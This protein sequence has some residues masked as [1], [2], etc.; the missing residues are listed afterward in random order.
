VNPD[1][2]VY[3]QYERVGVLCVRVCV[4]WLVDW[5]VSSGRSTGVFRLVGRLRISVIDISIVFK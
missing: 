4:W 1:K 3:S 5:G 2:E